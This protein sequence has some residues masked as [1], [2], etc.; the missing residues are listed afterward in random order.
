[1]KT[2]AKIGIFF[3]IVTVIVPSRIECSTQILPDTE[4][5]FNI[6]QKLDGTKCGKD[7]DDVSISLFE[8]MNTNKPHPS[9][10]VS[11]DPADVSKLVL[12][13]LNRRFSVTEQLKNTVSI[14]L[15]NGYKLNLVPITPHIPMFWGKNKPLL[16]RPVNLKWL[17]TPP[18]Q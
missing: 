13:V 15:Q 16:F 8:Y 3:A 9:Y 11:I 7:C 1:M 10:E 4:N 14:L 17:V 18:T 5:I 2:F 12:N 6:A